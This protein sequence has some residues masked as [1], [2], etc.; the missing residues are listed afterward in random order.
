MYVVCMYFLLCQVNDA[1]FQYNKPVITILYIF[2]L[3][4][5]FRVS[6]N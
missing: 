4:I 2:L 6:P 1:I 3:L 5:K